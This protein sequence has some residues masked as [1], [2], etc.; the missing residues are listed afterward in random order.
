MSQH[1]LTSRVYILSRFRDIPLKTAIPPSLI[2]AEIWGHIPRVNSPMLYSLEEQTSYKK[3]CSVSYMHTTQQTRRQTVRE[4][5][6]IYGAIPR[7]MQ[8]STSSKNCLVIFFTHDV[9]DKCEDDLI[10]KT[11]KILIHLTKVRDLY[12]QEIIQRKS[13]TKQLMTVQNAYCRACSM[14]GFWPLSTITSIQLQKYMRVQND[15]NEL[16]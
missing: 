4:K 11:L 5:R 8:W 13:K 16:N 1:F 10:K 7:D 12:D 9:A 6:T 14:W 2:P 15:R 3:S